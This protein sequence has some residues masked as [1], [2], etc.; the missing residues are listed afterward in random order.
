MQK[1]YQKSELGFAL[2]CIVLYVLGSS[3]AQM[4]SDTIGAPQLFTCLW[5]I[6]LSAVLLRFVLRM[7]AQRQ[8]GLCRVNCT[9]A[10]LLYYIPL[11]AVSLV[12]LLLGVGLVMPPLETF[13]GVVSM[14]CVGFL[15]ELIFRG[16]L[17]RAMAKDNLRVAIAVSAI[18]FGIG[19]IVNLLNG[20]ADLVPTV[21]QIIYATMF[22]YLFVW[23]FYRTGSLL[24][25][26]IAHA[27][28]N[29]SS[30]FVDM[31]TVSDT[32]TIAVSAAMCVVAVAYMLV[33]RKTL[34]NTTGM[35][36]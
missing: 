31:R 25:Q 30:V 19:H 29:A 35:M 6:L 18:T 16:L 9:S 11:I 12:N 24:P 36:E 22:G 15:E 33:L 17:F 7:G 1:L 34:R 26:M 8:Y 4:L 20:S 32:M 2:V 10:Q 21:C 13:F 5:H 27:V 28:L 23:M 14:V 3:V